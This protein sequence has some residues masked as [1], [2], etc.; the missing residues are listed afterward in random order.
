GSAASVSR[1]VLPLLPAALPTL[2]PVFWINILLC[3][4]S[5]V[6]LLWYTRLVRRTKMNM[7]VNL[8]DAYRVVSP[9]NDPRSPLGSDKVDFPDK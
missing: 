5:I 7:L 6:L 2:A 4:L 3:A 1:I 9:P 8:E